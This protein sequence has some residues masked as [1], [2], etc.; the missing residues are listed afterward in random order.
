MASPFVLWFLNYLCH[1][2]VDNS[3]LSTDRC[4]Y[5]LFFFLR[6]KIAH[7]ITCLKKPLVYIL[8]CFQA[9]EPYVQISFYG[10]LVF[11]SVQKV[12]RLRISWICTSVNSTRISK[13]CKGI[14]HSHTLMIGEMHAFTFSGEQE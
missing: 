8:I 9:A 7:I 3:R 4:C 5:N 13:L 2:S 1:S 10:S 6:K 12:N 11:V 14:G